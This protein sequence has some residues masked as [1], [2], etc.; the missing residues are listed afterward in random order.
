M[1][2]KT[3]IGA[4]AALGGWA[5]FVRQVKRTMVYDE[6]LIAAQTR[7]AE[8]EVNAAGCESLV[9]YLLPPNIIGE[10]KPVDARA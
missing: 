9:G 2:M 3:W 10:G 7:V 5:M 8:L 4:L 1:S 6:A